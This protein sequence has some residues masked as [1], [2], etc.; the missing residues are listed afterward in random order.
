MLNFSKLHVNGALGAVLMLASPAVAQVGL[1]LSPLRLELATKPGQTQTESLSLSNES[2]ATVHIRAS[3]LDFWIDDDQQPQFTA[4]GLSETG[5]SCRNWLKLNPTEFDLAPQEHRIVRYSIRYPD[6]LSEGSFHCAAGFTTSPQPG[7][8]ALGMVTNVRMITTFYAVHGHPK[9]EAKVAS[10]RFLPPD[11]A[12]IAK[13]K[14]VVQIENSGSTYFRVLGSLQVN[15][16]TGLVL[17]TVPFPAIPVLPNRM[18]PFA[19]A[20]KT[21]FAPG[22]MIRARVDIG[23]GEIQDVYVRATPAQPAVQ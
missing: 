16:E 20:L 7:E 18:Q 14:V 1:G 19:V 3:T 2:A 10:M 6:Q 13:R 23:N 21:E 17:E 8:G 11:D 9:A 12:A 4:A 15:D 22:Q 5:H